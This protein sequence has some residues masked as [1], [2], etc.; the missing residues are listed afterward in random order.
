MSDAARA[1]RG[2][3]D[4]RNAWRTGADFARWLRAHRGAVAMAAML[5]F[6][7]PAMFFSGAASV[8]REPTPS[9]LVVL[10]AWFSLFGLT[11][12]GSLLGVGFALQRAAAARRHPRAAAVIGACAA[13]AVAEMS[14]GRGQILVEQGV[15]QSIGR[16]HVYA[17]FVA[18]IMALL[19]IA[20]L[21]RSRAQEAAAARLRAAQAAQHAAR[22][23]LCCTRLQAV[24]ARVDPQ[25]LFDMLERVRRAYE[26]DA[27]RAERLLDELVRFL[28]AALPR[29]RSASTTVIGEAQLARAY[30]QLRALADDVDV[31]A[32]IRVADDV[33]GARFPP[34]VLLPLLDDALR[35]Q[36]GACAIV[37]DRAER[38]CRV[39]ITLPSPAR[40][41]TLTRVRV[42]LADLYGTAAR[43]AIAPER[44]ATRA[45][46]EIP[47]ESL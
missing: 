11:L 46:V 18:T 26:R 45:I 22:L 15:V 27:A 6:A 8:M 41:T 13:A 16:M 35:R 47:Y 5:S 19:F 14:N 17:F 12:W 9:N 7:A 30:A 24:Q 31:D 36:A 21:S 43:V 39:V 38:V 28:R 32:T 34:G 3:S 29:L 1:M 20:H 40:D 2:W 4:A 25:L 44:G 37:A 33:A 42:L 23:R 10:G